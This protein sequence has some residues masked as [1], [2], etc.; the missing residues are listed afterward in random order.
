MKK[1]FINGVL[2]LE[3]I[4]LRFIYELNEIKID[5]KIIF[6]IMIYFFVEVYKFNGLKI[7]DR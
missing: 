3:K 6:Y 4:F 5:G 2:N 7:I 1:D